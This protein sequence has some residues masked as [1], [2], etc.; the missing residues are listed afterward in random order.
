MCQVKVTENRSGLRG[1]QHVASTI[2]ASML[3]SMNFASRLRLRTWIALIWIGHGPAFI[4][5]A[6]AWRHR[7]L[8][9][10][11]KRSILHPN[12]IFWSCHIDRYMAKRAKQGQEQKAPNQCALQRSTDVKFAHTSGRN[13][14]SRSFG[15]G[16]SYW[17]RR[18]I[19]KH[20]LVVPSTLQTLS[21][22]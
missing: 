13:R 20:E 3:S 11:C 16:P 18:S 8:L 9:G 14:S 6:E 15:S 1:G 12:P 22:Q 21:S 17:R 10:Y 5:A 19:D 2:F 4:L 7:A